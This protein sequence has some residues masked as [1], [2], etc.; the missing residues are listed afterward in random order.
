[1]LLVDDSLLRMLLILTAAIVLVKNLPA[2]RRISR[3]TEMRISLEE[4]ISY[5]FDE[6]F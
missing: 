1:V 6:K 5:K 4:D 3:R 2:L